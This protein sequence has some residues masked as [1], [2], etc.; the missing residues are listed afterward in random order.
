[1][2]GVSEQIRLEKW[3]TTLGGTGNPTETVTKYNCWAEVMR[4]GGSK[5]SSNG[6]TVLPENVSFKLRFRPD[7][8]FT[9]NWKVVYNGLKYQVESIEKEAGKRF[10]MIIK[11]KGS[12]VRN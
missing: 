12:G 2:A 11:T 1:M 4:T 10:Y 6:Q 9:G 7:F 3:V 5:N 8:K